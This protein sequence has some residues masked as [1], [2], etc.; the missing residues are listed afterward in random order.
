MVGEKSYTTEVGGGLCVCV[1]GG[2]GE[3]ER[4]GV[5]MTAQVMKML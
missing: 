5:E 4:E 2:G 1:C 3:V